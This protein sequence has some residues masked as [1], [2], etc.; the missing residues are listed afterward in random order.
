M[1][2]LAPRLAL[3]F[4]N[5]ILDPGADSGH[6][7]F[8]L[9]CSK[10]FS[11]TSHSLVSRTGAKTRNTRDPLWVLFLAVPSMLRKTLSR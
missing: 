3:S 11:F 1:S 2:Y 9:G 7:M 5:F 8:C 4:R 6:D 10:D